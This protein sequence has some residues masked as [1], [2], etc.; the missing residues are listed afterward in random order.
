[1]TLPPFQFTINIR[2]GD[3]IQTAAFE[4]EQLKGIYDATE[5]H[6]R[7]TGI[8][9]LCSE[10]CRSNQVSFGFAERHVDQS[11]FGFAQTDVLPMFK[12]LLDALR[13]CGVALFFVLRV[14]DS[15]LGF[16]VYVLGGWCLCCSSSASWR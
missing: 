11:S 7:E 14:L 2:V 3:F 4:L 15:G 13:F 12:V 9:R 10:I 1:M 8:I 5:S 6:E 16:F